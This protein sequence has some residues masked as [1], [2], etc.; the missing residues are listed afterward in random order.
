VQLTDDEDSNQ[1]DD[2][3]NDS[4][5]EDGLQI[6]KTKPI[7]IGRVTNQL[8]LRLKMKV[9]KKINWNLQRLVS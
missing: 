5:D 6:L 9:S 1:D 4:D 8:E 3:K 2:Q 7:L